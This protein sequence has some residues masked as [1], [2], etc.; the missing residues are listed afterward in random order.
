MMTL[1]YRA[2]SKIEIMKTPGKKL[3]VKQTQR[4]P[5]ISF[6]F[7]LPSKK[8]K[9]HDIFY[10]FVMIDPDAPSQDQPFLG[11]MLH[12]MVLNISIHE[13]QGTTIMPYRGPNPGRGTG[14]HRYIF[15]FFWHEQ[16]LVMRGRP[17]KRRQHFDI[18]QWV[19]RYPVHFLTSTFF[20]A[21]R[22]KD[23]K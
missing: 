1:R 17:R 3:S 20:V 19:K 8:E 7:S 12:W 21:E 22:D 23:D 13:K 5:K 9:N 4:S 10:S 6:S 18:D 14:P 15:L 16:P 11:Q 2:D